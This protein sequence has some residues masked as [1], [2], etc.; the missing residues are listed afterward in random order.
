MGFRN[1]LVVFERPSAA[2]FHVKYG[3]YWAKVDIATREMIQ[4]NLPERALR[5]FQNLDRST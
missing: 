3:E 1:Y 2:T 4:G 5:L